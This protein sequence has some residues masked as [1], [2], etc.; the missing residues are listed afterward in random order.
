MAII[1]TLLPTLMLSGLI[2]PIASM[3]SLL[4]WITYF[5]PARYYLL[6]IRGI[7]LKGS[8]LFQLIKPIL[9]LGLLTFFLLTAAIRRMNTT[10]EK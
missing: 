4:Q 8:G 3:P 1:L 10:L 5:I 6:I 7:M 2:F 9:F